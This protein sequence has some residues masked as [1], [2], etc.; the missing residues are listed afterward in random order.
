MGAPYLQIFGTACGAAGKV[1]KVL[2]SE[3]TIN[4]SLKRGLK[5]KNLRGEINFDNVYFRY[6]ARPD[7]KVE[8]K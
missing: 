5:L 4:L 1:F 7:V 8:S 6:P 3:P 2:D